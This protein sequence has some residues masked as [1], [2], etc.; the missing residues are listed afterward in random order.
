MGLL[1]SKFSLP[2]IADAIRA[3]LLEKYGGIWLDT[4]TVILS[5]EARN[6]FSTNGNSEVT[7]FGDTEKR[8]VHLAVIRSIPSSRLMRLWTE[9]ISLTFPEEIE[10]ISRKNALPEISAFPDISRDAA[11]RRYYFLESRHLSEIRQ[12]ILLLHNSWT[13][14]VYREMSRDEFLRCDCTMTNIL[15]EALE[16]DRSG[17]TPDIKI[18]HRR[19]WRNCFRRRFVLSA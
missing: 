14:S 3:M 12:N 2:Q 8:N 10:I 18:E 11:Y 19:S 5:G 4:D 9:Y 13:P 6:F 17:I 16:I 7:F 15:C 1:D